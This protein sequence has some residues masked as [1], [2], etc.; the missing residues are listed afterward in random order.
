MY[1]F[2][3][4]KFK[5]GLVPEL[6]NWIQCKRNYQKQSKIAKHGSL[7][8]EPGRWHRKPGTQQTPFIPAAG[9]TANHNS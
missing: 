3:N 2:N 1:I 9:T 8:R 4:T 7:Y 6:Y 5:S